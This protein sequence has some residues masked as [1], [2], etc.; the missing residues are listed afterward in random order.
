MARR[1]MLNH[2]H[3]AEQPGAGALPAVELVDLR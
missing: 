3:W 1:T 2:V